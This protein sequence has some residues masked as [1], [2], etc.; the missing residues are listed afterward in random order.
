MYSYDNPLN[1]RNLKNEM[2][3]CLLCQLEPCPALYALTVWRLNAVDEKF[4]EME[5][6]S[7]IT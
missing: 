3:A 1:N 7:R 4:V 2:D 6:I 5:I